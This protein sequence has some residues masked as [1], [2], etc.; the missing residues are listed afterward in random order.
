METKTTIIFAEKAMEDK[1]GNYVKNPFGTLRLPSLPSYYS[2]ASHIVV[3]DLPMEEDAR[4]VFRFLGVKGEVITE[5]PELLLE[6]QD[7]VD[8]VNVNL[9]FEN[10]LLAE[11]GS[12]RLETVVNGQKVGENAFRI[13]SAP[14]NVQTLEFG[15]A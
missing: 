14:T 4:I 5:T 3:S 7:R 15:N 13:I 2:F 8:N 9:A 11:A 1:E 10:I 12:Y 6:K